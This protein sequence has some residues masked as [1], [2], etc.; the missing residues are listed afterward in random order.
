MQIKPY[1]EFGE[2]LTKHFPH[3]VQKVSINAGF[4][5]PNRDGSKAVGGCTYCN[6][7]SFSPGYGGKQRSVS[8]Q[9]KDGIA[10]F[11]YKYPEMKYLAYFQSYTNTYDST[12]KLIELYE[13]ALAYPNVVGLI[14]GTRPDCMPDELL[15]Y[16]EELNK[17]TFLMIEYGLEST[18]D[19]TLE[20]INRGHSHAE[21]VEAIKKT[22]ARG[23]S[24]GAHLIL[25]L[26]H[27]SKEQILAHADE[28]SK[29]PLTTV[30]LHQLQLIRGTVMAK[31]HR[32]HPEWFNLFKVEDYID[33]C[34]GFAERLNPDFVIE[35]FVSQSPK[36][37]LIAPDWGLKNFEFTAMVLKRFADRNT[38]QGK[39]YK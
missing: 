20:F 13:E 31:Q 4:T 38:W 3:K 1:K 15:N 8:D 39:L 24:T 6:N 28:I 25:G 35:R 19:S 37:L 12:D 17:R 21:S 36:Q 26:P 2:L 7:Q 27:E 23:I 14:I 5:C 10:F 34:I 30:K 32:E 18:L 16:F 22:A 29:L 9:L 11:S 33:L